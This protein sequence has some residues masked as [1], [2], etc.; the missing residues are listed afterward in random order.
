MKKFRLFG[1]LVTVLLLALGLTLSCD[2]GTTETDNTDPVTTTFFDAAN[3]ITITFSNKAIEARARAAGPNDGDYYQIKRGTALLSSGTIQLQGNGT[4]IKF[5]EDSGATFTGQFLNN[6]L[7]IN[8]TV[9]GQALTVSASTP[10][11]SGGGSPS[12]GPSG[13]GTSPSGGGGAAG[14]AAKIIA[15]WV[16][17]FEGE[18]DQG[19]SIK[20]ANQATTGY[21]PGKQPVE[22]AAGLSSGSSPTTAWQKALDFNGLAD[23]KEYAVWARAAAVSAAESEAAG[24]DGKTYAAG[25][26]VKGTALVTTKAKGVKGADIS[27]FIVAGN[28]VVVSGG[29]GPS[30]IIGIKLIYP[31]VVTDNP[32]VQLIEYAA[33]KTTTA[34]TSGWYPAATA[35]TGSGIPNLEPGTVYNLF[36]RTAYTVNNGVAYSAGAAK[37]GDQTI[38]T[39]LRTGSAITLGATEALRTIPTAQV[40][41]STFKTPGGELYVPTAPTLTTATTKQDI[42]Y[43]YS[44]TSAGNPTTSLTV[45]DTFVW[46]TPGDGPTAPTGTSTLVGLST[47]RVSLVEDGNGVGFKGILGT[48]DR[49]AGEYQ[50]YARSKKSAGYAAGEA[51]ALGSGASGV[52]VLIPAPAIAEFTPELVSAALGNEFTFKIVKDNTTTTLALTAPWIVEIT[53]FEFALADSEGALALDWDDLDLAATGNQCEDLATGTYDVLVRVKEIATNAIFAQSTDDK[54]GKGT[55]GLSTLSSAADPLN[56]LSKWEP[57]APTTNWKGLQFTVVGD[58]V[59]VNKADPPVTQTGVAVEYG[60]TTATPPATTGMILGDDDGSANITFEGLTQGATY[61]LYARIASTA[62]EKTGE[63]KAA[64]GAVA[65][66]VKTKDAAVPSK[67]VLDAITIGSRGIAGF[68][69]GAIPAASDG[70]DWEFGTTTSAND[71][72]TNWVATGGTL[73]NDGRTKAIT[74]LLA[75]TTYIVWMRSA[76]DPG[77]YDV[78]AKQQ[79]TARGQTLIKGASS[80]D[81]AGWLEENGVTAVIAGDD[82]YNASS[83][84]V[85][86]TWTGTLPALGGQPVEFGVSKAGAPGAGWADASAIGNGVSVASLVAIADAAAAY[87]VV[88]RAKAVDGAYGVGDEA[89]VGA[90]KTFN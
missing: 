13:G 67:A 51:R 85:K 35:I 52:K 89:P 59:V 32:G 73:S 69:V 23:E 80:D 78:G 63:W 75:D 31:A 19:F 49:T 33:S 30:E 77:N 34:P 16:V 28:S 40:G 4:T 26:S 83:V 24:G 68:T 64:G 38:T 1:V 42:E 9:G 86:I 6:L 72:P 21:N 22:Y 50:I 70:Q 74:G 44:A 57:A 53:D 27:S 84:T 58:A 3:N 37:K 12:T 10:G 62:A 39:N 76:A 60:A 41:V 18:T 55:A 7:T 45:A 61:Y 82:T 2:N 25:P 81:V 46:W 54:V 14:T 29:P 71:T 65:N 88:A 90:P 8:D 36:A 48:S 20:S 5:I 11:T 79:V 66:G 47:A 87:Q 43:T 17:D 15:P 56:V